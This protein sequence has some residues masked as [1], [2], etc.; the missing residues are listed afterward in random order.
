VREDSEK[1]RKI[2]FVQKS[3]FPS[4]KEIFLEKKFHEN[5]GDFVRRFM[6][7]NGEH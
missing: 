2:S 7:K 4:T 3:K 6:S 1:Q 5:S